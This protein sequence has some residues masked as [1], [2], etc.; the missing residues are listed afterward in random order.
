[1]EIANIAISGA[2]LIGGM[3]VIFAFSNGFRD[4]S[5]IVA[6]VVST[7]ALA[8]ST[9]FMVC[10]FF[11]VIGALFIGS[12][13][14]VTIGKN[15]FAPQFVPPAGETFMVLASA[16]GAAI[17]WGGVSWWRAWPTSNNQA[18]TAA[19]IGASVAAWGVE[20]FNHGTL[21]LVLVV[22]VT[23]PL[24]GFLVSTVVTW[25]I[26]LAGEWMTPR[27][28]PHIKR[29][30]IAASCF[31]SCAHGSND[32]QMAMGVLV[33]GL[34]FSGGSFE[35]PFVVRLIVAL[36]IAGGVLM[37][38]QRI[39]KKLGMQFY[40]I[41][42]TQGLGAQVTSASTILTCAL[43]GFPA[44]TMQVTTGSIVGAGVARNPKAVRWQVVRDIALSW[45]ITIPTVALISF[46]VC[47]FVQK[48]V[49]G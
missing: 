1:M 43:T 26:R 35:V 7:R 9:A 33:L 32:G 6:T 14:V 36:S 28:A 12:A 16:L 38:G 47:T 3:V 29:L 25:L 24:I 21:V 41:K 19:L 34:G 15:L 45:I 46:G 18:I 48:W 39:L 5:T 23:S 30:Q 13:V 8:P 27:V 11:E 20:S 22:L 49:T 10:A 2:I 42:P 17:L 31:L 40:H 37:G 44:S 4:S